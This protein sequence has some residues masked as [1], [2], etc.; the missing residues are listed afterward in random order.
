MVFRLVK[1]GVVGVGSVGLLGALVFGRDVASYLGCSARSVQT[2]VRDSV[3]VEFELERARDMVEGIIPEL[4]A[5]IRLIA[6]EE[7]EIAALQ[8]DIDRSQER[9]EEEKSRIA[10]QRDTLET[11]QVSHKRNGR[12]PSRQHLAHELAQRF[13]HYKEGQI[14]LASKQRLLETRERSLQAAVQMLDRTRARKS[15]IQQQIESLAAQHRLLKA[16]AVTAQVQID[17]SKLARAEKLLSQ[18]TKRLDIAERVLKHESEFIPIEPEDVVNE[19]DLMSELDEYFTNEDRIAAS[20]T[21][22]ES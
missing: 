3:P 5:N 20:Q 1:Y 9:L 11:Q 19:A 22:D 4:Q 17:G 13:G 2:A 12:Q 10:Q 7:V 14:I 18:I 6:Q 8:K 16:A 15:Q 21:P